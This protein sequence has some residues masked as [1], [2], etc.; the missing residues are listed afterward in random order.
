[1]KKMT[2]GSMIDVIFKTPFIEKIFTVINPER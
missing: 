1:M 2:F